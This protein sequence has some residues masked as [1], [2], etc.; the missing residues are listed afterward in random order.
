MRQTHMQR[1][2]AGF[3]LIELV[4]AVAI[5]GLLASV[6]V[7]LSQLAVQRT[8]E[9]DLRRGL[10]DIREAIDAYK[11]AYDDG[12]LVRASGQNGYPPDLR[13]LTEG[14]ADAKS[15]G[16][17]LLFLR[18]VPRDP[19]FDNPKAAAEATW[20][21]RAYDSPVDSPREGRDVFDVYSLSKKSGLGGV[22]YRE[23]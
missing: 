19:F 20:G 14:A 2:A 15:P 21:L 9:Q 10:R 16:K 6:A 1:R 8:K 18:R 13:T 23:W 22:P 17:K 4:I 5:V 7:P 12:R 3:T 11:R